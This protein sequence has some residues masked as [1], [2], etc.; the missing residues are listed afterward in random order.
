ME[1]EPVKPLNFSRHILSFAEKFSDRSQHPH[2]NLSREY[3][4]INVPPVP[5]LHNFDT[6]PRMPNYL[7]KIHLNP[8]YQK[9]NV[10][11]N[12]DPM[13]FSNKYTT[14]IE[15]TKDVRNEN[16]IVEADIQED[17]EEEEEQNSDSQPRKSRRSR[18]TFTTFQLHQLE[19]TFEKTQ[20]PDVF[21]REELAMRLELS[22]ARVQVRKN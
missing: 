12:S 13:E 20:Y 5:M 8:G 7:K 21:T 1:V 16:R 19:Q 11:R 10:T 15:M 3:Q 14:D 4:D 22:E 9:I 17:F 2:P 6:E 18:T